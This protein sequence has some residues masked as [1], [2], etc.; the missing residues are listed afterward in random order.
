M[1]RRQ[2]IWRQSDKR[3]PEC[4][5]AD[6]SKIKAIPEDCPLSANEMRLAECLLR[7]FGKPEAITFIPQLQDARAPYTSLTDLRIERRCR[8][9]RHVLDWLCGSANR[10]HR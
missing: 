6:T 7:S 8:R 4:A 9:L 10:E 2:P 5:V 3:R 1:G